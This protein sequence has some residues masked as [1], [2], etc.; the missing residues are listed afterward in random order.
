MKRTRSR[1]RNEIEIRVWALPRTGHHAIMNWIASMVGEPVYLFE[2]LRCMY[3][4][5]QSAD[6]YRTRFNTADILLRRAP[7]FEEIYASLPP[8]RKWP[9]EQIRPVRMLQK[10]CIM[11]SYVASHRAYYH[12]WNLFNGDSV[13]DR[14]Y[15]VGRSQSKFDVLIVRDVQNWLASFVAS[16]NS[17]PNGWSRY[18]HEPHI[19]NKYLDYWQI[20]ARE[21][22]GRTHYLPCEGFEKVCIGFNQ[23]FSSRAY[24]KRIAERLGLEYSE[25]YLNRLS[26]IGFSPFADGQG[27]T[28]DG[29]RYRGRAQ[30]MRVLERYKMLEG[31]RLEMYN[32]LLAPRHE[33]LELSTAII[34]GDV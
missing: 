28:F 7:Q 30:K 3:R 24:R 13:R 33:A 17:K 1:Y 34:F 18:G 23:W 25:Q 11:Y 4:G 12:F 16:G 2:T 31:E 10:R 20:S 9:E 26:P 14:E 27:S 6:P 19:F 15:T 32:R 22:L 21:F 8:M 29:A 5:P